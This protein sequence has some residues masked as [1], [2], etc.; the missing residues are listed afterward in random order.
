METTTFR[1]RWL[2]T[3]EY[4]ELQQSLIPHLKVLMCGINAF[5]PQWCGCIFILYYSH[6]NSALLLHK[7]VLVTYLLAHTLFELLGCHIV[8]H[9]LTQQD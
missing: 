2:I 3:F 1:I 7:T 5:S 8:Q 6:L 4:L 9:Q